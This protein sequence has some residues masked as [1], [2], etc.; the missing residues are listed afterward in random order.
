MRRKPTPRK[1]FYPESFTALVPFG[2]ERW[3]RAGHEC[4]HL[5]CAVRLSLRLNSF[6]QLPDG[7]YIIRPGS[8]EAFPATLTT[9]FAD[10]TDWNLFSDD[11]FALSNLPEA[12][13]CF[14]QFAL[15]AHGHPR[16]TFEPTPNI[17]ASRRPCGTSGFPSSQRA[18]DSN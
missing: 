5:C 16:K 18:K 17:F 3:L 8:G 2:S 4:G 12:E 15:A 10:I 14:D 13:E 1:S 11:L 9:D 7:I 6:N